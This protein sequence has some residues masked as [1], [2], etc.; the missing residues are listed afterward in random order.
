MAD[1]ATIADARR[2]Y[3]AEITRRIEMSGPGDL[4]VEAAFASV[5]RE[6]CLTPPPWRIFA[7]GGLFDVTT[8]DPAKLYDDVLVV[9]DAGRGINNGQPS[10][11]AAWMMAVAPNPGERV[12]QIGAG[13][14]YYTAI[15]AE[16]VGEAGTVD[17]YEIEPDLAA[18]AARNLAPWRQVRLRAESGAGEL[19]PADVVYVAAGIAAPPAGWLS[20]LRP[21]GRLIFPWQPSATGGTTL[22]VRRQERG[23]SAASSFGVSFIPCIGPDTGRGRAVREPVD[24]ARARSIWLSRDRQPDGSAIAKYDE[25]WISSAPI[26]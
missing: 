15:L 6:R 20:A 26:E 10:L 19:P 23:F 12:V 25:V 7:P 17:A 4:R 8:S 3:A 21:E 18:I 13:S 14:G 16:L 22:L 2:R 1:D 5:P 11:H 9:L 24:A